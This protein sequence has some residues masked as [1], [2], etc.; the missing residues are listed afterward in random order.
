MPLFLIYCA[1]F[2]HDG[3]NRRNCCMDVVG[4]KRQEDG[5]KR[6]CRLRVVGLC[7]FFLRSKSVEELLTRTCALHIRGSY[8]PVSEY[9]VA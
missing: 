8:G 1:L 9:P 6:A 4:W 2:V 5:L 7:G 3:R